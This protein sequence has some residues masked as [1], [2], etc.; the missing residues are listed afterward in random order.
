MEFNKD[1]QLDTSQVEDRRGGGGRL[2]GVP[3]GGLAIGGGGGCVTIIIIIVALLLG[4]N[5]LS[6]FEG[7]G[8]VPDTQPGVQATQGA[9]GGGLA[10]NCQTG[11]DAS[12]KED[13]RIVGYINSIQQYWK[14]EYARRGATYQPSSTVFYTDRT[15]S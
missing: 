9:G 1:A 13:C 10:Q 4:V 11:V 8:T 6:L 3:G 5:P 14:D 15:Q 7:G 12:Q 2:G